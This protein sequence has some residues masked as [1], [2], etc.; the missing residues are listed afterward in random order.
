MARWFDGTTGNA[1][2]ATGDPFFFPNAW[3]LSLWAN[4]DRTGANEHFVCHQGG[5]LPIVMGMAGGG[6]DGTTG[7]LFTGFF[8]DV[9]PLVW[10]VARWQVPPVGRWLQCVGVWDGTDI[11]LWIDGKL[12][13][14]NTAGS[15][16]PMAPTAGS[17]FRLGVNWTGADFYNGRLEHVAIWDEALKDREIL[18][19]AKGSSPAT[20]RPNGLFS[21]WP[22]NGSPIELDRT[23]SQQHFT[24]VGTTRPAMGVRI[25]MD[26]YGIGAVEVSGT[27]PD[28]SDTAECYINIQVISA[29][30]YESADAGT[31]YYDI[32][33]VSSEATIFVDVNTVRVSLSIDS[34]D[35]LTRWDASQL[36]ALPFERW[37]TQANHRWLGSGA[38]DR[39]IVVAGDGLEEC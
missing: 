15:G 1:T 35:C 28:K 26:S 31:I 32:Q 9:G 10:R 4:I 14:R 7:T 20:I 27:G 30:A 33:P 25:E 29:D 5:L 11:S 16:V 37:E 39:F 22:L 6:S 21:Y 2:I 13:G 23:T 24:A 18:A 17:D 34:H 19:L 38:I 8:T 36:F 3:S 12:V